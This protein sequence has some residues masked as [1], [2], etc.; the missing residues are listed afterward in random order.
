MHVAQI[1]NGSPGV[2]KEIGQDVSQDGIEPPTSCA[3]NVFRTALA[4]PFG[5]TDSKNSIAGV[6]PT[7]VSNLN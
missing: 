6:S 7:D 1:R 5:A 3:S 2:G 4:L